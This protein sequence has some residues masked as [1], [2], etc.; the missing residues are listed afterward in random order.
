MG[1]GAV[2]TGSVQGSL[3]VGGYAWCFAVSLRPFI[4]K[5]R[6]WV[7]RPSKLFES[8]VCG[9]DGDPGINM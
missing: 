4:A 9:M 6:R 3:P 8:G 5:E 2:I 1:Y 7:F